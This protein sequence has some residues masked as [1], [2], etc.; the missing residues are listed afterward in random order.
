M[1]DPSLTFSAV[2]DKRV[3]VRLVRPEQR[4]KRAPATKQTDG[5]EREKGTLRPIRPILK[6]KKERE[7]R[8]SG[9]ML[10]NSASDPS[11]STRCWPRTWQLAIYVGVLRTI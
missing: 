10:S 11:I 2:L 3:A 8:G 5:G 7:S 9:L 6:K 4:A 1:Y